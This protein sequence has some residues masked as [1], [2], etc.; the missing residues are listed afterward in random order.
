MR[1]EFERKNYI[2]RFTHFCELFPRLIFSSPISHE[3]CAHFTHVK[4]D[5]IPCG[6]FVEYFY[7]AEEDCYRTAILQEFWGDLKV[8][9]TGGGMLTPAVWNNSFYFNDKH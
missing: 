7:H 3:I 2:V 6:I 9:Y 1:Q 4:C 8:Y 5:K